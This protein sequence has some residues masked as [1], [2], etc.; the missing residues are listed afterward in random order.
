MPRPRLFGNSSRTVYINS[1]RTV[2]FDYFRTCKGSCGQIFSCLRASS[3]ANI[4]V[5]WNSLSAFW[6]VVVSA[7]GSGFCPENPGSKISFFRGAGGSGI[8]RFNSTLSCVGQPF[9]TAVDNL[10]TCQP[11]ASR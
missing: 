2:P 7:G 10:E 8:S 9:S 11:S 6:G 5:G 3:I 1:A 4:P